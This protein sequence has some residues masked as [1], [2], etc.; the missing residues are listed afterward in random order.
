VRTPDGTLWRYHYDPLGRRVAKERLGPD[1]ESVVE[2]TEF[3]WDGPVLAEQSTAP[4]GQLPHRTTL[5]WDY[6][7]L[8]PI[9]QT[10][11]L[12]DEATQVEIDA[13]F[14][15]ITTDL[16]GTPTELVDEQGRIAWQSRA[17]L[18]GVTAW[19]AD[20][21]AYT[22]LRF[23]GQ[24]FDPESGL[25][26]N[27]HRYYDPL[28][29]RYTTPDPLGLAPAPDPAGYVHNPCTTSDPLGLAPYENNGGLGELQK[30]NKPDPAADKLAEKLGGESRLKFE[31]DPSGREFDAISDDYV[32]QTKPEGMQMGSAFRNQAKATFERSIESGR[33]PYFHFEGEPTPEVIN[34]LKDYGRRYGIE[35][36][37]DISP[38]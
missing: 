5:T 21:D 24:Y 15:A 28:T 34:K 22:P 26:Y 17:T 23:P 6:D 14:F 29:A 8:T 27:H 35:P 19:N 18:W 7:G 4:N 31:N 30:V 2:R 16:I 9:A 38:L 32:A 37:I 36:V 13:R 33:T 25:H 11:R 20:A 3:V 10:E 1:G 12:T